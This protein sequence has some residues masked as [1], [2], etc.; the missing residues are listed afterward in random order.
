MAVVCS[1]NPSLLASSDKHL[2]NIET[3]PSTCLV[4]R[5]NLYL[6]FL[7]LMYERIASIIP[8]KREPLYV[9]TRPKFT[10]DELEYAVPC[11]KNHSPAVRLL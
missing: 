6:L 9:M 7:P 5:R 4:C 1:I 8:H 11:V 3:L 10:L 2:Q